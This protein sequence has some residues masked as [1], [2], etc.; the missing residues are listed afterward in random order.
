MRI[1][2]DIVIAIHHMK[3]SAVTGWVVS[4]T[5]ISG[6]RKPDRVFGPYAGS[7]LTAPYL[8]IQPP[9]R[10]RSTELSQHL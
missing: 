3:S 1:R 4:F 6:L 9:D 8:A 7:A 5:S 2:S 10:S